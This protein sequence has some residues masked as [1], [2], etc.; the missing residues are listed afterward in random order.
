M[1]K[2]DAVFKR[3]GNE[4]NGFNPLGELREWHIW[5]TLFFAGCGIIGLLIWITKGIIWIVN[6][7]Q[8]I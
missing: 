1:C 6:H 3:G 7:I 4:M 5:L 8:F 2:V